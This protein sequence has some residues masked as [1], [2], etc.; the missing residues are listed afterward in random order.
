MTLYDVQP[1]L[2]LSVF[3]K[4]SNLKSSSEVRIRNHF[5]CFSQAYPES[6]LDTLVLIIQAQR[7]HM[8]RE[9]KLMKV[10][11]ISPYARYKRT[12]EFEFAEKTSLP[13]QHI[14][15]ISEMKH[16]VEE[17]TYYA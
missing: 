6:I 14:T 12:I 15:E 2:K 13:Q 1:E 16:Q 9:M 3:D 7:G 8:K 10:L 4:N 11:P 5:S 17:V